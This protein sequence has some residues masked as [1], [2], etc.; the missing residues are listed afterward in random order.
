[1]ALNTDFNVSPYFDDYNED[2]NFHRILFRPAVP[3]QARELTQLQTILQNQVERF[4]DNIYRQG[5]IIKGCSLNFDFNYTYIKINDLQVDGQTTLVSDYA[6]GYIEDSS[7]L[8]AEIVNYVQGLESQNPD[9]STLFIKYVGTGTA[10]KKTYANGDVLTV[11]ARDYS[12]Q[13]ISVSSVGTLYN[14][15]DVIVFTSNSGTGASANIV[16]FANGSIRDVVISDGGSGYLTAPT[17]TI[18][19]ST[20][21]SG[22]L[23]ALNY[24]AQIRVANSSFTAPVGTGAAVTVGDGVIYQRGHFVRVEEQTT[25]AS[26]Y[27]N[28]PSNVALGFVTTESIVNNSVDS[29]LLD[30]AQGYSNYTAPGAHRLKLTPTLVAISTA[31][32]AANSEFLS[33]LEFQNG[34]ITKRRTGTEF[35]SVASEFAKRTREES[36]NYVVNPFSIYTEEKASN[37]THLNLSVSSGIGY[38]DGFRS[39]ITGTIRVPVRKGTDT[40]TSN[41]QTISTNFGNYVVVD[42][43]LGNFDFS[44]GATINLRDAAGTDVTDNFGGAPTSPGSI[45]GTAKVKSFT[46]ESGTPGTSTCKYRIYLFNISMTPGKVFGAVRSLQVTDGVADVVL[47][48]GEAVLKETSYDT[49]IFSSGANAVSFFSNE[50]FIYRRVGS[51]SIIGSG[52]ASVQLTGAEEFPYTASSTLNDT[53][54][55]EFILIPTAN[56]HSTTNLTGTVSTSG[57]V[58]TGTAT[59][60]IGDLDVGD[61]VKFSGNNSFYRVSTLSSPISMTLEGSTGPAVTANTISYAFPK[62]V[63]VRLNRGSANVSIDSNGNTASIFVGGTISGTTSATVYCN[64]KVDGASPKAKSVVKSVY[65]KLSTAKI[66]ANTVGPW[67]IGVP[68]AYKLVGVYVGS[69]NTYSNT[70]TNYASSFEL[71]TGQTDNIYGLS[72][73]RKKPGSSLSLTATNNLLVRVDLFTHGSGYYL[74]TESYPVDDATTTLPANKIRTEDIPY[75]RSPRDNKYFN[76]RDSIDFRPIVANT[77]NASATSVA[78]AT[79][80][81][82]SAENLSGT[83]YFPTPNESFQADI[84]HYLKRVDTV[85]LD[86][87]GNVTVVEGVPEENPVAPRATDGTMKLATVVVPPYPSLSPKAATQSQRFE[88]ST[89]IQND[90]IRG[91]TMKDIKQI[92]DRIN[93][94]EYYSLLNTLEKSASDLI[95]PSEAN[96]QSSR[97][98]NGFF[99]DSFSSYDISNVNDPEYLIYVDTTTATARPQIEKTRIS[100]VANTTASSNITFKGEYALLNY[101]ESVFIDQPIANKTRNPT[102]LA[103]SFKGNVRLFPKYDDYYDIQKGSVNMTIDLATPLNALTKAINDNVSFKKDS[104]QINVD[105]GNF[106]TQIAATQNSGGIDE[107]TITTTTTTITNQLVPGDTV[108]NKQAVGEF[109]TDFGL[110]PYIRSQWI[111][112]VAVGLRPNATHFVFFDKVDVS[113]NVRQADLA[114]ISTMDSRGIFET[115]NAKFVGPTGAPLVSND[116]GVIVGALYIPEET[117]F[118]GDRSFI[119]ADSNNLDTLETSISAAKASFNA[120]NFYKNSAEL[121]TT[122]KVPGTITAVSNTSVDVQKTIE[123]R[124]TPQLPRPGGGGGG[125]GKDPIAQTF[126]IDRADTSDGVYITS[127]DLFFRAKD[128]TLGVTVQLRE[129]NNG[130]PSP[131]VIGEAF[132]TNSSINVSNTAAL[133]TTVTF[134]TPIYCK[135]KKDYCLIIIPDQFSPEFLLWVAETGI[136]DVSN[137]SIISTSNWGSGSLF[138]SQNDSTW[139]PYQGEDLKFKAYIANFNKTSGTVVFENASYEFLTLSNTSGSFTLSEEVAQKSNTYLSGT[140]TCNTTSAV[141]NTSTSQTGAVAVGEYVLILYANNSSAKTGTINVSSSSTTNVTGNGTLFDNEYDAGDYL[142]INNTHIREVTSVVSNTLLTIDAPLPSSLATNVHVGVTETI[143]I[144]RVNA[145]NSSTITLKDTPLFVIDGGNTYFGAL[146]KVVRATVDVLNNDGTLVLRDSTASNSTFKFES[147]KNIVGETSQATAT[148]SSVDNKTVNF[149]ESYLRYIAPPTNSVGLIQRIDGVSETAANTLMVEG[150]SNNLRYEGQ[151]KSRSN[152]ISSGSKS[153]RLFANLSRSNNFIG[154]SPAVDISPASVITLEN[155]INNDYTN[156]TTSYGNSQVRYISKNVVLADGLDAEDIKVY[157]TAYK[158]STSDI[159]VYAKLLA[160]DD[161]NSFDSRDWTLLQQTTESNLYSDS[162]NERNYIE[163]EYG[164]QLTPPS[165]SIVGVITSSSNTTLT[166]SGSSFNV[167]LVANDVIKVVQ[168]NTLTGYDIAVVDAVANSTSMTLKANTS[169][170]G[171]ASIEKVTQPGAAF[172]YNRESNIVTYLD[173]SRGRHSTY[174]TFAI[175][176]VLVSSSTKYVPILKDVRALAVSI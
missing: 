85:V 34:T 48:D 165:S 140:F 101:T 91:Y 12:I 38:V 111:T 72:S 133:A 162:L 71:I 70:G 103:W 77:A 31:N 170:S 22:S 43:V 125:G 37:T 53:Q 90:Q 9:L 130:Y 81:P 154:Q 15:T 2:K 87:Y 52:V 20:G 14:N 126:N 163:Y 151:I 164:L 62:N 93:R 150:I 41:N 174:K 50:Q 36:G 42:Q 35:N 54:E 158:P 169:F 136:P 118:V 117:F 65:V 45:I 3:I 121:T 127:V 106:Q 119:I 155:I 55:L 46:Y 58:V 6:N 110:K 76:L 7:N 69:S 40:V 64:S 84:T 27:T 109:L 56:A 166:G 153:F 124:A 122:T 157:I 13:S 95:I 107:R 88:Y 102:Q 11:Y 89:L 114:T 60:F 113:N 79:I 137:N 29:T 73:I 120:Y 5:T 159:L 112:F 167:D 100:L 33:I 134:D 128:P 132:V 26:K 135:S 147:S 152:E 30:N 19:T 47:E 61:Y 57:N 83:L 32:A 44:T 172:K 129:T 141:V 63:P 82:S 161:N 28:Q 149:T 175:K 131:V 173:S 148:I 145:A 156:E 80:D 160:S 23:T 25:I 67:I 104:Q 39:E 96:T 144:T 8:K 24:I 146:Q 49:L 105:V 97:F 17:L 139:T 123:T 75:Y 176:I 98:K 143:Q 94:I 74:S 115:P 18:T 78:G 138:L 66:S 51:T 168:S 99:A 86:A 10:G 4:G 1:M 171:I 59:D 21:S 108:S 116:K 92:E 16:T 68:D 142:L